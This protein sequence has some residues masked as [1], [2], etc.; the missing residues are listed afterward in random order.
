MT[1]QFES[2]SDLF[3]MAGHGPYVWG[4]YGITAVVMIYLAV[5][6]LRKHKQFLLEQKRLQRIKQRKVTS[7]EVV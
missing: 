2:I 7:G 3:A 1:F 6:P 5:S 4:S